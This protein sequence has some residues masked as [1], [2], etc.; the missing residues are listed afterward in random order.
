MRMSDDDY[1][2]ARKLLTDLEQRI[3][4][5]PASVKPVFMGIAWLH[6]L[7]RSHE[8]EQG[9]RVIMGKE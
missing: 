2:E 9:R 1:R 5:A 7:V 4:A 3:D 6:G 8:A